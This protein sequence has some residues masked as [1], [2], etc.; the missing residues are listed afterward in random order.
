MCALM[1]EEA[2]TE[3]NC[4]SSDLLLFC[5]DEQAMSHLTSFLVRAE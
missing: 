2:Q 4:F 3:H 5:S 1:F